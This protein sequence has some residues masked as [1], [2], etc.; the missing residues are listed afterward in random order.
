MKY[1]ITS[2]RWDVPMEVYMEFDATNDG[3]T[4]S[5]E[6]ARKVFREITER[7]ENS[8]ETMFLH[9]VDQVEKT[10]ILATVRV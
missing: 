10:T 2:G 4:T 8:W 7:K 6:K 9:R 3:D 5:D 1:R